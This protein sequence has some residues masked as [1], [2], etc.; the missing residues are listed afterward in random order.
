M[1]IFYKSLRVGQYGKEF[2]LFKFRSMVQGADKMGG[3]STSQDDV[4]IT[5]VGRFL[6]KYKIDEFP[7]IINVF[8]GDINFVGPRP[9]VREV[10]ETLTPEEKE[11]ILSIKPGITGMGALYDFQEE[12]ALKGS[13]DPHKKFLKEIY[14][15]IIK[16]EIWYVKNRNWKLD[17]KILW[18][19]FLKIFLRIKGYDKI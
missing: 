10:I 4:R 8:R 1:S 11:I 17:L 5:S 7:E 6:R 15:E 13:P 16:R 19:T 14:P 3:A 12:E 9:T 18:W 2:T